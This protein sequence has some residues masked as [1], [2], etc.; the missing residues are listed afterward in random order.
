MPHQ[1]HWDGEGMGC[2]V[3]GA[4]AVGLIL[5]LSVMRHI[6]EATMWFLETYWPVLAILVAIV[7]A[8]FVMRAAWRVGRNVRLKSKFGTLLPLKLKDHI[9][10]IRKIV[11]RVSRLK[12]KIVQSISAASHLA[13][14]DREIAKAKIESDLR[15]LRA[16]QKDANKTWDDANAVKKTALNLIGEIPNDKFDRTIAALDA[17]LALIRESKLKVDADVAEAENALANG[18]N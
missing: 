18:T 13:K 15:R 2:L 4:G 17:D 12:E 14:E 3:I 16:V 9:H 5:L 1:V 11:D 6:F 8:L 7:F 10:R